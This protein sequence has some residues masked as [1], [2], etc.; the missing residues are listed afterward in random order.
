VAKQ[1]LNL[2]IEAAEQGIWEKYG[3]KIVGVDIAAIEKTKTAKL[4]AS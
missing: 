1:R 3:V 2:C 4:F